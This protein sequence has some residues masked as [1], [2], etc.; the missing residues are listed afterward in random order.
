MVTSAMMTVTT[1]LCV[2]AETVMLKKWV[3]MY[4]QTNATTPETQAL[5]KVVSIWIGPFGS[6]EHEECGAGREKERRAEGPKAITHGPWPVRRGLQGE[7]KHDEPR[8][9]GSRKHGADHVQREAHDVAFGSGCA[10][11]ACNAS[12]PASSRAS[13]AAQSSAVGCWPLSTL[14]KART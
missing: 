4:W 2:S 13:S 6:E 10:A 11:A 5:S 3:M 9:S 8:H 1:R 14:M 12:L 7:A